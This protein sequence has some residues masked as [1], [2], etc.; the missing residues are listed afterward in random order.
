MV[1]LDSIENHQ[2]YL[3]VTAS[4]TA[5]VNKILFVTRSGDHFNYEESYKM[6]RI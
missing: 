2:Y 6:I 1:S 5:A 3:S 4:G